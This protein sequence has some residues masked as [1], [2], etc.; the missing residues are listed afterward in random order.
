MTISH[1]LVIQKLTDGY[2]N[3]QL[4]WFNKAPHRNYTL[5]KD[6]LE[7]D[8]GILTFLLNP[9]RLDDEE[10]FF[11]L[12]A[13]EKSKLSYVGKSQLEQYV[14][15]TKEGLKQAG[16]SWGKFY[17]QQKAALDATQTGTKALGASFKTLGKNILAMGVNMLAFTAVSLAIQ[18]I[19]TAIDN[20]VHASERAIEAAEKMK[21]SW[22]ELDENQKKAE[23]T[24]AES[25]KRLFDLSKGVDSEGNNLSLTSE[26]YE[27][28][29]SLSN[30]LA[31]IF[32][33]MVQGFNAQGDAILNTTGGLEGLNAQ[34]KE[35]QRNTR[36][37][38]LDLLTKK[39]SE[40]GKTGAEGMVARL[41]SGDKGSYTRL[42]E[43]RKA[44]EVLPNSEAPETYLSEWRLDP[45][46]EGQTSWETA[47]RLVEGFKD[48]YEYA[49]RLEATEAYNNND[50][51][52]AAVAG[53][54]NVLT[55]IGDG[56]YQFEGYN[57]NGQQ[58]NE[59]NKQ[60]AA[61][62]IAEAKAAVDRV[63]KEQ[64]AKQQT[65][66][67]T[68]VKDFR[69]VARIVLDEAFDLGGDAYWGGGELADKGISDTLTNAL[70]R[71]VSHL[72]AEI[73]AQVKNGED[74][75]SLLNSWVEEISENGAYRENLENL[76]KIQT[77][78]SKG[79]ATAGE[80]QA[81]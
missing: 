72:P 36:S 21:E 57:I 24:V 75:R 66:V 46:I 34:L 29:I 7:A 6:A 35:L 54:Y 55:D 18:G 79:E 14:T 47:V 2:G 41:F 51:I 22:S 65:L 1:W 80:L 73:F 48:A 5:Q 50:K 78:Y 30:E 27:E 77:K 61:D 63:I 68:D 13:Q 49:H 23:D 42:Q 37:Q 17:G 11:K 38:K 69:E 44:Q 19:V 8:N 76:S 3:L 56:N 16:D 43:L 28:Y 81:R 52:V 9:D 15:T 32:P 4:E 20:A 10:G 58:G 39:D 33:T 64:I 67:D 40:T 25:G 31:G 70:Y 60:W 74:L 12:L 59:Y 26:Q 53:L 71:T 45:L 62:K